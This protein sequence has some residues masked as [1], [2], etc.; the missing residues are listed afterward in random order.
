MKTIKLQ[1]E[2]PSLDELRALAGNESILL[3]FED[4]QRY[5]VEAADEFDREVAKL[6]SSEK[7]MSF[8]EARAKESAA[9]SIEEF[10][11]DLDSTD[12]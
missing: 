11:R 9:T 4:G 8:L 3:I 1:K 7:F 6:G 2:R 12:A 5:V 10:A